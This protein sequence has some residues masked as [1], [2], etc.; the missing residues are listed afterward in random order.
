MEI[1]WNI[2][3]ARLKSQIGDVGM[4]DWFETA[5]FEEQETENIIY[6][7]NN[8]IR[9]WLISNYEHI[10][11][12]IFSDYSSKQFSIKVKNN[13]IFNH[14]LE[15]NN[16]QQELLTPYSLPLDR[17]M[18]F[19]AFVIGKSNEI[20][21][22]AAKKVA[23]STEIGLFNPLFLYGGVGL[24]KTHL[25]NAIGLNMLTQGKKVCYISAENFM[26]RFIQNFRSN[27]MMSF[28]EEFRSVD[29]LL[30]EDFQ[31]IGGKN[32]T[33]EEFFHTFVSLVLQKK[34]LVLSADKPI[35]ELIGVEE[36]LKSR[37]GG[38]M[39]INLHPASYELRYAI[40]KSK[41]EKMQFQ[42]D[43]KIVDY[44]AENI[45]SNVRDLEGALK[46]IMGYQSVYQKPLTLPIVQ[47]ILKD[48]I[49]K[50]KIRLNDIMQHVSS[51][52]KVEMAHMKSSKRLKK[53]VI[54]RQ[55]AMYLSRELTTA[56]S[57]E[58]GLAFGGKDHSTALYGCKKVAKKIEDDVIF[59]A[60]IH[61]LITLIKN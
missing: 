11:K 56:S 7:G 30:L 36:R 35:S 23:E 43:T 44:I 38:G 54:A 21:Y 20:A 48:C 5:S 41:L 60:E 57:T 53:L 40:L 29:V 13:F 37:I 34:Q 22:C 6:V 9:N 39:V 3:K 19:D 2:V 26:M 52:Y 8:F 32:S 42:L 59:A 24:G 55:I 47:S 61:E 17:E 27:D 15:A 58:I 46:K 1:S 14:S 31:F 33:Q 45:T 12:S 10:I 4:G 28:K 25:L 49:P 51:Y 50:K 18:T 16:L